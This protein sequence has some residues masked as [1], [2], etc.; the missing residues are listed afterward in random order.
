[1]KKIKQ[2]YNNKNNIINIDFKENNM[3][4]KKILSAL[5][6]MKRDGS[7]KRK[8]KRKNIN[9]DSTMDSDIVNNIDKGD[10]KSRKKRKIYHFSTT[11]TT[12]AKETVY[13]VC[14]HYKC[15][16]NAMSK[17]LTLYKKQQ[18]QWHFE[19]CKN[20]KDDVKNDLFYHF[21]RTS[22]KM[23][24]WHGLYKTSKLLMKHLKNH[25]HYFNINNNNNGNDK[26]NI[27]SGNNHKHIIGSEC[28]FS[29]CK[30]PL[31]TI[32]DIE[33]HFM[34]RHYLSVIISVK[35]QKMTK[36]Q[37][38]VMKIIKKKTQNKKK[39]NQ[40]QNHW[41]F[42]VNMTPIINGWNKCNMCENIYSEECYVEKHSLL[43]HSNQT[44]PL[45]QHYDCR[46]DTKERDYYHNTDDKKTIEIINELFKTKKEVQTSKKISTTTPS[47]IL[48]TMK[49]MKIDTML[50]AINHR[51]LYNHKEHSPETLL[52]TLW[53]TEGVK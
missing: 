30:L 31:M 21:L 33:Q 38:Q 5:A 48:L 40:Q 20:H 2:Y 13:Y 10:S 53:L 8:R 51:L 4:R 16:H 17:L 44:P 35:C 32:N 19:H 42:S 29:D 14:P 24:E 26:N 49:R 15:H 6:I 34:Y 27:I 7:K 23:H 22:S 47:S 36:N 43:K 39:D 28:I 37:L 1:M 50:E 25:H 9:D 52:K 12:T 41:L 11:T 45:Y 3:R 46:E 18:K